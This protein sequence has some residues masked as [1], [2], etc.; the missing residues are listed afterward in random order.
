MVSMKKYFALIVLF[1]AVTVGSAG[2][3]YGSDSSDGDEDT[4]GCSITIDGK[5]LSMPQN[6]YI[7]MLGYPVLSFYDLNTTDYSIKNSVTI[8]LPA[9]FTAKKYSGDDFTSTTDLSFSYTKTDGA[10][11]YSPVNGDIIDF[12]LTILENTET[13]VTGTFS[14]MLYSYNKTEQKK[15]SGKFTVL[16]I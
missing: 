14:G 11:S 1:S 13:Q 12:T 9:N 6:D 16:K 10:K 2:C 5:T 15:V 7:T 8:T 4:N 3:D